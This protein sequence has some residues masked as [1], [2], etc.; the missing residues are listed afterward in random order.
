MGRETEPT[1]DPVLIDRL[2]LFLAQ[3]EGR[4][5]ELE[6]KKEFSVSALTSNDLLEM[7]SVQRDIAY[8]RRDY[9]DFL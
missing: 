8:I 5:A 6:L 9:G 1:I 3:C 4:L 7:Q 2:K